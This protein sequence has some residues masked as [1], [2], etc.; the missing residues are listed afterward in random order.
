VSIK[1]ENKWM[2]EVNHGPQ[3]CV[4]D[5]NE[6][7]RLTSTMVG[8]VGYVTDTSSYQNILATSSM[9]G[10]VKIWDTRVS[11]G[12]TMTLLNSRIA[13]SKSF[14]A[15]CLAGQGSICFAGG[16]GQSV[17]CWDLR[18]RSSASSSSS[19]S[20]STE[21][22]NSSNSGGRLL[23]ELSTG[24]QSVKD[25]IWH[26][27]SSTLIAK[28]EGHTGRMGQCYTENW[29]QMDEGDDHGCTFWPSRFALRRPGHYS[30]NYCV[31]DDACFLYTFAPGAREPG[32]I[33][34]NMEPYFHDNDSHW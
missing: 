31:A 20:S 23:Y 2:C 16:N 1:E 12:A 29:K 22:S 14:N 11:G 4:Y 7:G 21:K 15:V 9:D 28:C 30:K 33:P 32:C 6:G 5:M 3:L 8:H 13:E 10:T 34:P 24:T 27:G 25:L 17:M 26:E 19:S 18:A